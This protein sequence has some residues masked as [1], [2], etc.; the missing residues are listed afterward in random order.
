MAALRAALNP[1]DTPYLYF[2]ADAQGNTRFSADL[3]EHDRQVAA[4][5]A[6]QGR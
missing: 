2:V 6:A 4:Y 5:R 1:A 3:A